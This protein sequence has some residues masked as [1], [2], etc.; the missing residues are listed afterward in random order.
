MRAVK[1]GRIINISSMGGKMYTPLGA[2]YHSTKYAL[3]GWSDCLR[4]EL[5]Q[6]D[7][8]VVIIEPGAIRTEF[9]DVMYQPMIDAAGNGPY[10]ELTEKVAAAS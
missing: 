5:K 6:F 9:L 10:R 1:S 7:I 3:E 8:D 2:W 4:L